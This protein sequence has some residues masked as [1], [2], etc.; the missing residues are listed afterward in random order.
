MVPLLL[1]VCFLGLA[2][3]D[4]ILPVW[5]ELLLIAVVGIAP[6]LWMQWQRPFYIFSLLPL[7]LQPAQLTEAQRRL[8]T[9]FQSPRNRVVAIATALLWLV[10][11]QR[12]YYGSAMAVSVAPLPPSARELGLLLAAIAFLASHLFIQVPVSVLGVMLNSEATVTATL[13][14]ALE[15]IPSSF[16]ILGLQLR[17]ILPPVIVEGRSVSAAP[18][19]TASSGLSWGN[20]VL[21]EDPWASAGTPQSAVGDPL[22]QI[23]VPPSSPL[24]NDLPAN[25]PP[26]EA[27]SRSHPLDA[28]SPDVPAQD[29]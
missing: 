15:T 28:N 20:T 1:E 24:T 10:V 7:A 23:A 9:L 2:V 11:L 19:A 13:P 14:Q 12:L 29:S 25:V 22:S 8:L 16:T 3:G 21:E 5:L 17:Q 27:G 18:P 26:D 6:V 4:P